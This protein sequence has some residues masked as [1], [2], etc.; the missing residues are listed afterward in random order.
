MVQNDLNQS[1]VWCLRCLN[2]IENVCLVVSHFFLI[3]LF[4]FAVYLLVS[5]WNVQFL[6]CVLHEQKSGQMSRTDKDK[7][8]TANRFAW[9][10][11]V[12]FIVHV[13]KLI[14]HNAQHKKHQSKINKFRLFC[15]SL[16]SVRFDFIGFV[17]VCALIVSF[18]LSHLFIYFCNKSDDKKK[19]T[20]MK[21]K[22]RRDKREQ[23]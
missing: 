15:S 6:W 16:K 9:H 18:S 13:S 11:T 5:V 21:S 10:L 22:R 23:C 7:E 2:T 4:P 3:S 12:P 17:P 1:F 19:S 14:T 8:K 20:A